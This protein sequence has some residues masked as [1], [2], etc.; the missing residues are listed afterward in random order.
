YIP[1]LN[2]LASSYRRSNNVEQAITF[3]ERITQLNPNND[4]AHAK[5]AR[6]QA[7]K[8]DMEK[9]V[10]GYKKAISINQEQPDW[11]FIGLG[12]ALRS[13]QKSS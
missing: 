9:A 3:L 1:A 6:I 5:L 12:K 4:K 8:G 7:N 2:K 10:I 13:L 11:A